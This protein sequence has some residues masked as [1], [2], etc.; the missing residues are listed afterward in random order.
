MDKFYIIANK[1]KDKN[2]ESTRR[3]QNYLRE[4]GCV[5]E[6]PKDGPLPPQTQCLIVLGGDGTLLHAAL[7]YVAYDIPI[8]GIN[9]GTLGFLTDL[10]KDEVYPGLDQLISD[11]YRIEQRM[12]L[13][14]AVYKQGKKVEESLALNDI[15]VT[16]SGF[17]RLVETRMFINDVVM[18]NYA[19]DGVIVSTPTG[20][21]GYN[22]SAGGPVVL[23]ESELMV[24]T[25]ICPHSLSARSIVVSA[26]DR[27]QIEI[28]HR[29]KTQPE[30][31]LV[32]FDGQTVVKLQS[33]D[34][35]RIRRAGERVHL[36][37]VNSRTFYEILRMKI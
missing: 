6:T 13:R 33:G 29:Q 21:T 3:I 34:Y 19:G 12:M 18:D 24:I 25:P 10:E 27:V 35:I 36:V 26:Q 9:L 20:S 5:C 8:L 7:D 31:A 1:E 2:Y 32:T 23:P 22:L 17:S 11:D 16:R 15:I 4:R 37:K 28:G 30:E 14:G